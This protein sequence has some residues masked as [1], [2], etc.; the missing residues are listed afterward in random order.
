M[1]WKSI[2]SA[3]SRLEKNIFWYLWG[4]YLSPSERS[5]TL[6][7]KADFTPNLVQQ[8]L[9]ADFHP[10]YTSILMSKSL[11]TFR[12]GLSS[13]T[14]CENEN[15]FFILQN[16]YNNKGEIKYNEYLNMKGWQGK[17]DTTTIYS[18]VIFCRNNHIVIM[19]SHVHLLS[20]TPSRKPGLKSP[21][22][23]L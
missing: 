21:W 18:W 3:S 5:P 8:S 11:I 17:G 20:C 4:I 2:N 6:D 10:G 7:F 19:L 14:L 15:H 12:V 13:L 9:D 16:R 22:R 1:R 23:P